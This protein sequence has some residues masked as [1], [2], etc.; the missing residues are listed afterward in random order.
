M[1]GLRELQYGEDAI[2]AE[3]APQLAQT[4]AQMLEVPY[5][6]SHRGGIEDAGRERQMQGIRCR[7]P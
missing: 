4:G 1:S 2:R 7:Q 5:S 6:E 3:D